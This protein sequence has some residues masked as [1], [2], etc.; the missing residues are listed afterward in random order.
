[1]EVMVGIAIV[2]IISVPLLNMFATSFKVGRYSYNIDNANAA[3]LRTVEAFKAGTLPYTLDANGLYEQTDYYDYNWN[4]TDEFNASFKVYTEI[5]GR[6]D[7]DSQMDSAYLPQLVSVSGTSYSITADI[8]ALPA[9]PAYT[10]TLTLTKDGSYYTL[11]CSDPI[12]KKAG[13]ALVR[14]VS[15]PATDLTSSV[16]PV[17]VDN[18]LN[19]AGQVQFRV[20]GTSGMELGLFVF[21]DNGENSLVSMTVTG[22]GASITKLDSDMEAL[23]FDTLV[24]HVQAVRMSD[25]VVISDFETM[26]YVVQ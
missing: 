11:T 4:P 6:F 24:I 9:S 13:S 17:V 19:T 8:P 22:G 23:R 10:P 7:P 21:G 20:T 25:G 12:L 5:E 16:L 14:T 3:A 2:A 18:R 15:V 1:M 26:S